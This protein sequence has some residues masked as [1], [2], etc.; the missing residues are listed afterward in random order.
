MTPEERAK[1][2]L[3]TWFTAITD[4]PTDAIDLLA[5]AIRAAVE[6]E[7]EACAKLGDEEAG[8]HAGEMARLKRNDLAGVIEEK[9]MRTAKEI[10]HKIRARS[11]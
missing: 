7:R 9:A 11:L 8:Y 4:W 2:T 6:E 1:E 5:S 10:A 3:K